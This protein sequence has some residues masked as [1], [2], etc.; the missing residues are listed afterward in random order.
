[1]TRNNLSCISIINKS[2]ESVNN[3]AFHKKHVALACILSGDALLWHLRLGHPS[4]KIVHAVLHKEQ[5]VCN[6]YDLFNVCKA[7][8]MKKKKLINCLLSILI[9]RLTTLVHIDV[10]G[11]APIVY[12]NGHRWYFVFIDEF[13]PFTWIY[14]LKEKSGVKHDFLMFKA[15]VELQIS[16]K[17]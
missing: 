14:F 1:M 11:H 16:F 2:Q 8:Q 3:S 7:C 12:S 4:S 17:I 10:W 6:L 15:Q 5:I 13:T 9:E